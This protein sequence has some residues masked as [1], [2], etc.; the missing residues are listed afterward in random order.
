MGV[1]RSFLGGES[2]LE[3]LWVV[4]FGSRLRLLYTGIAV[5]RQVFCVQERPR[6]LWVPIRR[7][8]MCGSR[9]TMGA[10]YS[11]VAR[12]SS[13]HVISKIPVAPCTP[14]TRRPLRNPVPLRRS[15]TNCAI[16]ARKAACCC[17]DRASKSEPK[18]ANQAKVGNGR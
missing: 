8:M 17:G 11:K 6:M 4:I 14:L 5:V 9:A 3:V 13:A 15:P 16:A 18:R 12:P 10:P 1:R 2:S 7:Q